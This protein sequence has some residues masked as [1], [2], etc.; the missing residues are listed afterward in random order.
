VDARYRRS[1]RWVLI[2]SGVLGLLCAADMLLVT[3]VY[4]GHSN[5]ALWSIEERLP[6]WAVWGAAPPAEVTML[7]VGSLCALLLVAGR[8]PIKVCAALAAAW[9]VYAQAAFGSDSRWAQQ[10]AES[11]DTTP[12]WVGG[13]VGVAV[14]LAVSVLALV[15]AARPTGVAKS[16]PGDVAQAPLS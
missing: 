8:W 2:V 13:L 16:L 9:F 11:F 5:H 15:I 3:L 14:L 6:S 12:F 7:I 4:Y 10:M 1:L